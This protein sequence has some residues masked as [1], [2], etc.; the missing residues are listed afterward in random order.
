MLEMVRTAAPNKTPSYAGADQ[1]NFS[2]PAL[3]ALLS[4]STTVTVNQLK[5]MFGLNTNLARV[6]LMRIGK[7]TNGG[8][9][10]PKDSWGPMNYFFNPDARGAAF[11]PSALHSPGLSAKGPAV[12]YVKELNDKRKAIDKALPPVIVKGTAT[13]IHVK[14]SYHGGSEEL[15]P[16]NADDS[17]LLFKATPAN[18]PGKKTHA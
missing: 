6:T 1:K 2:A 8:S 17:R 15:R 11:P 7:D 14:L 18:T 16:T 3:K 10:W 13:P 9:L 4:P 12:G 5:N